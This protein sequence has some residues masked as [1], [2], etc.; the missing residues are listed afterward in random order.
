VWAVA[1]SLQSHPHYDPYFLW[2]CAALGVTL[3]LFGELLARLRVALARS[4]DR[5]VRVL[6]GL[7]AAVFVSDES[8][9]LF[10]NEWLGRM[11]DRSHAPQAD[12]IAA[13]FPIAVTAPTVS[14]TRPRTFRSAATKCATPSTAA[15]ISRRR[16]RS[17]GRTA[18]ACASR[19]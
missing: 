3:L 8:H 18:G 7:H 14:P 16:A 12:D 9:V 5:F 15:G 2:D 1:F 19:C 13:R 6:S 4:D 10:A 11:L 17:R